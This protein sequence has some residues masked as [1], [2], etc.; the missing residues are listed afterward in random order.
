MI[1]PSCGFQNQE[2]VPI[3]TQCGQSLLPNA[4]VESNQVLQQ[5]SVPAVPSRKKIVFI[6]LALFLVVV[7]SAGLFFFFKTEEKVKVGTV[8]DE[9]RQFQPSG[10][11]ATVVLPTPTNEKFILPTSA[12]SYFDEVYQKAKE[13]SPRAALIQVSNSQLTTM[14]K[15]TKEGLSNHWNFIFLDSS[16]PVGSQIFSI[17]LNNGSDLLVDRSRVSG[18]E[19]FKYQGDISAEIGKMDSTEAYQIAMQNGGEQRARRFEVESVRFFF[20]HNLELS[21]NSTRLLTWN[22]VFS[23]QKDLQTGQKP[24][25]FKFFI[26]PT[27]KKILAKTRFKDFTELVPE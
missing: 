1:C 27:T 8:K 12:F 20:G 4:S 5:L 9:V 6:F 16:A 25:E 21:Q 13:V 23:Y 7:V 24:W 18:V 10:E 11:A 3:C 14:P 15:V 22:I 17:V 2:G 19:G 26:D